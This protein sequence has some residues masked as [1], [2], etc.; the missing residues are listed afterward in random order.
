MRNKLYK[1]TGKYIALP[2]H[3]HYCAVNFM[4]LF[5]FAV[6][7]L[8]DT[9]YV[10]KTISENYSTQYNVTN[11]KCDKINGSRVYK[12]IKSALE[13]MAVGDVIVLRGGVYREGRITLPAK[14]GTGWE[15]GKHN[16]I[17]SFKGEWAVLDGENKLINV[18]W[19]AVIGYGNAR[20][21]WKFERLEICNGA[22]ENDSAARGF[23]AD[24][25]PF[26][27]RY[28]YF[29]DNLCDYVGNIPA[30]ISGHNWNEC[31]IE[32]CYFKDNGSLN[33]IHHNASHIT[34]YSDYNGNNIAKN[35]FVLGVGNHTM[36]N[37]LRC[38]LFDGGSNGMYET[39]SDQ[40]FTGR[41]VG[42]AGY[43]DTY[44]SF[45]DRIH[46]NIFMNLSYGAIVC[47]QDFQQ[48]YNNIISDCRS[49]FLIG[50]V[51][52]FVYKTVVYNNTLVN[53]RREGIYE[54]QWHNYSDTT[55][56][57]EPMY[58]GYVY[59]N[60]LDS[61]TR[62]ETYN[63]E[64]ITLGVASTGFNNPRQDS[65]KV[66]NCYIYRP[67]SHAKDPDGSNVMYIAEKRY[68]IPAYDSS[69][70]RE[71]VF[72]L[73]NPI[74]DV[75]GSLYKKTISKQ[76]QSI[77]I[78]NPLYQNK[79][80]AGRFKTDSNHT[81]GWTGVK[82]G[83]AGL[84][85]PHPYLD[86]IIPVYIGATDPNDPTNSRWVDD[87]LN[88]VNLNSN[89]P[90]HVSNVK[91][92]GGSVINTGTVDTISWSAEDDEFV[93]SCVAELSVNGGQ[94]WQQIAT[95]T[96]GRQI[97]WNVPN[98]SSTHCYIRVTAYDDFAKAG[99][100]VSPL[101]SIK[102]KKKIANLDIRQIGDSTVLISWNP[103]IFDSTDAV[104]FGV[105]FDTSGCAE[106]VARIGYDTVMYNLETRSDTISGLLNG[107]TYYFS[108]FVL[109]SLGEFTMWKDSGCVA[110][111]LADVTPPT[112]RFS[113]KVNQ[114]D[115]NSVSVIW[116]NHHIGEKSDADSIGIWYRADLYPQ[117]AGD[118]QATLFKTGAVS[119]GVDTL[120]G[121]QAN[122]YY[123]FSLFVRDSAGNWSAA[124]DSSRFRIFMV[125]SGEKV[126]G[127]FS[128]PPEGG[129]K[130]SGDTIWLFG[131]TLKLW[132]TPD[133]AGKIQDT[134]DLWNPLTLNPV[135]FTS[136]GPGFQFRTGGQII[137]GAMY[138]SALAFERNDS[139]SGEHI[140]IFDNF[141]NRWSN[142]IVSEKT[143][144]AQGTRVTTVIKDLEFPRA[145]LIDTMP[146]RLS[147]QP[148]VRIVANG[149]SFNEEVILVDNV[150][151]CKTALFA[152][153]GG[154]EFDLVTDSIPSSP[155]DSTIKHLAIT[156]PGIVVNQCKGVKAM[157]TAFD[158]TQ[159]DTIYISRPVARTSGGACETNVSSPMQ[160]TPVLTTGVPGEPA[161]GTVIAHSAGTTSDWSYDK[162]EIRIYKY[163]DADPGKPQ[164][165]DW[166]EY[167]RG[168]EQL[169]SLAPGEVFWIKSR[170]TLSLNTGTE[171]VPSLL[172]TQTFI[173]NSHEWTDCAVPF[174]FD[175]PLAA[176]LDA[177][178]G[179]N[180]NI[181]D[182]IEIYSWVKVDSVYYTKPF[183]LPKVET[184]QTANRVLEANAPYSLFNP[185]NRAITVR[186]PG[187]VSS[188]VKS[189]LKKGKAAGNRR[190]WSVEIAVDGKEK[191][192]S[193]AYCG[194]MPG[195][196][197]VTWYPKSPTFSTC[198]VSLLDTLTGKEYGHCVYSGNEKDGMVFPF[199]V[200]D[201]NGPVALT[202]GAC[203]N[204]SDSIKIG[205][206]NPATQGLTR[207]ITW[208]NSERKYEVFLVAGTSGFIG[209]LGQRFAPAKASILGVSLLNMGR[210]CII[211]YTL[212]AKEFDF[213]R[214][215][216]FDMTGRRV[217]QNQI[218]TGNKPG[219]N[220]YLFFNGKVHGIPAQGTYIVQLTVKITG[221]KK[222]QQSAR[223]MTLV[224]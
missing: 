137:K 16:T 196:E 216:L 152:S 204:V 122:R 77:Q 14:D 171:I 31:L 221:I 50:S 41:N 2:L 98:H 184:L 161:F 176:F 138:I 157:V 58:Y 6:T 113:L 46:H 180:N 83:H 78:S 90:P 10:D 119:D 27:F 179:A 109:D 59:N 127:A 148:R 223:K 66:S 144:S 134:I 181:A 29:H 133:F 219:R 135:G 136:A 4:L 91:I 82:I 75:Y 73:C 214:F 88:L 93:E 17:T 102:I 108:T 123:Y 158:G 15:P 178:A 198:P 21:Y 118:I 170:N 192:Y 106:S 183:Y 47:N 44:K 114:L 103:S 203:C 32:Y 182:S 96:N 112:N 38:N 194:Y 149:T 13:G 190:G 54:L 89:L 115:T 202:V 70:D 147:I 18:P 9:I 153:P 224:R 60:L 117:K 193:P 23:H 210:T 130:G 97:V 215:D 87:V 168:N 95:T 209:T 205:F 110:F 217:V 86:D 94:T 12:S 64:E 142:D 84:N 37:E 7:I 128:F 61:C 104:A 164:S 72:Y 218:T 124:T 139:L 199:V 65:F 207:S 145:L 208:R 173:I 200:K 220:Q 162:K 33:S 172:D 111:R 71:A 39:K 76:L 150:Y 48:I 69:F 49:G 62:E 121:L 43:A 101:F 174:N 85:K 165:A 45:G 211:H 74:G 36:K 100:A 105:M 160:W 213:I 11:R 30:A 51:N 22:T 191:E 80:G 167:G 206:Y 99:T 55:I 35:G 53:C 120:K 8:P 81:V 189:T 129:S 28:C 186:F 52:S 197:G 20:S 116:A 188:A 141:N 159:A 26:I 25:G 131:D 156:V 3:V 56:N 143:I 126:P 40:Y 163:Y 185:Q 63:K 187:I 195:G 24:K 212:P 34:M 5:F 154:E 146:P 177:S 68:N 166:L 132:F 79:N 67:A 19:V 92:A 1:N 140:Y 125:K 155:M 107:H 201:G 57:V 222:V 42:I 175:Y 169:F 151:N